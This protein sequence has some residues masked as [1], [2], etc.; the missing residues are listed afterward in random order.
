MRKFIRIG[1][2]IVIILGCI[3][4]IIGIS[5]A[6]TSEEDKP[7]VAAAAANTIEYGLQLVLHTLEYKYYSDTIQIYMTLED[8]QEVN[9]ELQQLDTEIEMLSKVIYRE[10]RGLDATHRAAVVWCILNRVDHEGYGDTIQST[11]TSPN[12]FAYYPDT[13]VLD[14]HTEIA[15]DVVTRW[16]IEHKGYSDVGRVLPEDYLFFTGDGQFNYFRQNFNSTT[17]WNWNMDSPY[18]VE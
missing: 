1:L 17:F 11:L 6:K 8:I 4:T 12:Q 9:L 16:L 13:P 2:C 3:F 14:S 7:V 18:L 10:A 5:T 15:K